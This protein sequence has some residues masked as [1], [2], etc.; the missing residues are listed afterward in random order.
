[1][2]EA[3]KAAEALEFEYHPGEGKTSNE[4]G[5]NFYHIGG[6]GGV[7]AEMMAVPNLEQSQKVMMERLKREKDRDQRAKFGNAGLRLAA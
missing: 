5:V 1:M 6:R 2:K 4:E 7:F 3:E